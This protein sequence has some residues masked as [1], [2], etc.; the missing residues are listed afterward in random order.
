MR[1]IR[2]LFIIVIAFAAS[3]AA[4]CNMQI[5]YSVEDIQ[6]TVHGTLRMLLPNGNTVVLIDDTTRQIKKDYNLNQLGEYRITAIFSSNT[7]GRDSLEK[8]FMLT[9]EEY[10]VEAMLH[11]QKESKN[12]YDWN[13]K[14]SITSGHFKIIKYSNPSPSVKIS[15]LRYYNTGEIGE[16]QGPLFVV[17]N[18]SQDTIYGEY[19]PGYLWG[20]LF[21]WRDGE[22]VGAKGG[23]IDL[24]FNPEPPLYPNSEKLAWV[25]SFGRKITPGKY[26]F[27]LYYSTEDRAKGSSKLT[28]ETDSFRWWSDVQNWHLLTCEFETDFH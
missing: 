28:C 23:M 26:R 16:V 6:S 8:T 15:F 10:K 12:W 21:M 7:S 22:Y 19:L 17:K 14:E 3:A 27:N 5:D 4:Q 25:G 20:T 24:D 9:G 13:N 18:E 1:K 11:F 2:F